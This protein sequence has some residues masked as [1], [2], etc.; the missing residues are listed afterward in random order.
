MHL[1]QHMPRRVGCRHGADGR[2]QDIENA[3]RV[4]LFQRDADVTGVN[5]TAQPASGRL[6]AVSDVEAA[7][8]E[9]ELSEVVVL[10]REYGGGQHSYNFV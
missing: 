9:V 8:N 5:A 2:W 6:V 3:R 4:R 1:N 10:V 7:V